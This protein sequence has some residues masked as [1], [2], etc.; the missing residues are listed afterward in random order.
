MQKDIRPRK[1][2]FRPCGCFL[3]FLEI[4]LA[5]LERAPMFRPYL[6]A[7]AYL[8]GTTASPCS[9]SSHRRGRL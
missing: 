2:T 9:A 6:A 8:K 4:Q 3:H 5:G 1:N 7:P